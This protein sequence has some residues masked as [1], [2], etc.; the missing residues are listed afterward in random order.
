MDRWGNTPED[1]IE[2]SFGPSLGELRDLRGRK[3]VR[4][5]SHFD[6]PQR[7]EAI[8]GEPLGGRP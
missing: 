6:S 3:N 7:R 1:R 8:S 5:W 2:L 4:G